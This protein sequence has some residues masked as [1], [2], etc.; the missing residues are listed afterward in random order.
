M[1]D[2]TRHKRRYRCEFSNY[3]TR[4]EYDIHCV[5]RHSGKPGYPGLVD[6]QKDGLK[7]QKYE[8]VDLECLS[9]VFQNRA[10]P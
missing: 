4:K 9:S 6:I 7:P 1:D 10:T 8:V 3:Q 5:T 2:V